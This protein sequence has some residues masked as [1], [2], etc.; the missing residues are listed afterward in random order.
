MNLQSLFQIKVLPKWFVTKHHNARLS[1]YLGLLMALG[2]MGLWQTALAQSNQSLNYPNRPVKI[3]VPF[4][5]GGPTDVQARW[6]AEQ[7]SNALGQAFIV[8]NIAGAG[9]VTGTDKVAKS[10]ADGY[11]LLAGNPGPLTVAPGIKAQMPY[12]TMTDFVPIML[13]ARRGSCLTIHPSVP[14]KN[15]KEFIAYVKA[16]PGKVNYGSPGVGRLGI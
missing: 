11:T 3:I 10:P 15:V 1:N 2:V 16:N 4:T 7:L 8:E 6:A 13:I 14:A 12:L 5:A 9:G